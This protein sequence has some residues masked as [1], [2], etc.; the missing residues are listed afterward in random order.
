MW[1][2][3]GHAGLGI[4]RP[5]VVPQ[6]PCDHGKSIPFSVLGLGMC[7]DYEIQYRDRAVRASVQAG[8][9][10]RCEMGQILLWPRVLIPLDSSLGQHEEWG[11]LDLVL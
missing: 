11:R 10:T 4:R 5:E 6:V 3:I 7:C 9:R 8:G 2:R 1:N